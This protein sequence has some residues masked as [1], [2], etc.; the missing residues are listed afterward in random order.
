MNKTI[1]NNTSACQVCLYVDIENE[2]CEITGED[3]K[4]E[5]NWKPDNCPLE[6]KH[7]EEVCRVCGS[8]EVHSKEYGKSTM[9]CIVYLQD[10]SSLQLE[11]VKEA[12]KLLGGHQHSKTICKAIS[13]LQGICKPNG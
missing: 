10:Q 5:F 11:K 1:S 6:K 7:P 12:I 2:K 3:V 4:L 9:H 13:I 8:K